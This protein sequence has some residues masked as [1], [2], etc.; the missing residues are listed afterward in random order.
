MS[1]PAIQTRISEVAEMIKKCFQSDKEIVY[2]G[3]DRPGDPSV[4]QADISRLSSLG[5]RQEVS[6]REGIGNYCRWFES[7]YGK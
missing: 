2:S 5:F 1:P 7:V 3:S 6:L 4:W